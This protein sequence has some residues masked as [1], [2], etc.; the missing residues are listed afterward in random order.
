MS[1]ASSLAVVAAV[2]AAG[3]GVAL[4]HA[5]AGSRSAVV[6]H[7]LGPTGS[8]D[9]PPEWFLQ[10]LAAS[11]LTL[12][13][14]RAW[15]MAI[16][17]AAGAALLLAWRWP[18]LVVA[19]GA[20]VV[21]VVRTRRRARQRKERRNYDAH[22]VAVIDG[23]VSHIATGSSLS[24]ALHEGAGH[25]S[26]V[27]RDLLEVDQRHRHGEGLQ[28]ALDRW[29]RTRGTPGVRLLAD[30]LAIAGRSGGSQRGALV[31]VQATLR[32]RESLGREVRAL[33]SQARTSGV[34]L[35]VTPAAF[36]AVV[37][38]VDSRVAAFYSTPAGWGCLV[39]GAALDAVGALWMHRLT[40]AHS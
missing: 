11:G 15:S 13:P 7:R 34:V 29:A 36:A 1:P 4:Q 39:V 25:P 16:R 28:A 35:A 6:A 21:V 17:C 40:E 33:A 12:A 26:P 38:L 23:L 9:G 2:A 5:V 37:A 30:A 14:A 24:M 19:G 10:A 3:C 27:G 18:Q 8:D 22:L 32:D 20:S 31:G